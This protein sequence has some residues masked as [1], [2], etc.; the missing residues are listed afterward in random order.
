MTNITILVVDDEPKFLEL[1]KDL[2][3]SE[4]YE[5]VITEIDPQKVMSL[6]RKKDFDLI[7]LDVYMPRLNGIDLLQK[8]HRSYPQIPVIMIT[9]VETIDI[10]VKA[11]K[12]GT[13]EYLTKSPEPE[14]LMLTVKRAL[15]QRILELELD[16]IHSLSP[17][18]KFKRE[19]FGKIIIESPQMFK[20]FELVQI[21]APTNEIILLTVETGTGKDLLAK[22]IHEL[23][24]RNK[25]LLLRLFCSLFRPLYL[26]ASYSVT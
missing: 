9:A 4:G 1:M 13:Y 3:I 8:I 15:E 25:K 24:P 17:V 19:S 7:M 23:S 5:N 14:R 10:A 21:F 12:S 20:I 6:L 22:K 26:R 18:I 16:S 2:L 11:I